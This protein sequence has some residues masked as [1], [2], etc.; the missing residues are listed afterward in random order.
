LSWAATGVFDGYWK[1]DT[2]AFQGDWYITGDT[3]RQ[4]ADGHFY[5]IGL[6]LETIRQRA[7][8]Q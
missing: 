3:M 6:F 4:D 1:A 5:F 8:E 7:Q 2:P